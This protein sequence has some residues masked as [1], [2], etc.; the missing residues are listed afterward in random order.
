MATRYAGY[1]S[2]VVYAET[3][4]KKGKKAVQHLLWGDWLRTLG[5]S[6]AQKGIFQKVHARGVDGGIRRSHRTRVER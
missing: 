4:G 5:G 2:A 1:P 6:N 3:N